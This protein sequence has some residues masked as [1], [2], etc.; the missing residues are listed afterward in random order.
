MPD[1]SSD[2]CAAVRPLDMIFNGMVMHGGCLHGNTHLI[3][4]V[5]IVIMTCDLSLFTYI[6]NYI[7][8]Y[9]S[10]YLSIYLSTYLPIYL[11]TYLPIY[12]STYLPIYLSI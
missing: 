8:T 11:S 6:P 5:S 3:I 7:P 2:I 1:R 12:L 4:Y 9:L 10:A